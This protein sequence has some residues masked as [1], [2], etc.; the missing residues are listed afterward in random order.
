MSEAM[1]EIFQKPHY[2]IQKTEKVAWHGV[3]WKEANRAFETELN[4]HIAELAAL[5][6]QDAAQDYVKY[7]HAL[8]GKDFK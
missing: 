5:K 3:G 2:E 1:N 6:G 4:R 8:D 7:L